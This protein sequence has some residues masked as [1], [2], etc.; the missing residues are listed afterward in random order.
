MSLVL[1]LLLA[2]AIVAVIVW[3]PRWRA[4]RREAWAARPFPPAWRAVLRRRVPLY[5]RLPV[6]LQ[7]QL[8]RHVQVFLAEKQIVGCGGLEVTDEMRVTV[9]AHAGLL[10][11]NRAGPLYP[12][13][14]RVLLYPAAF[15]VERLQP[16]AG[17]VL[18]EERRVLSG[19]SWSRGQVI[20]S[21]PD[22][23]EGARIADDGHNVALHE[24]AHQLDQQSGPA[25]GAPRQPTNALQARWARTMTAEYE[26]LH[27][28]L[29]WHARFGDAGDGGEP[30]PPEL[31]DP[32][33]AT[34]PAEFFAVATEVFFERAP[35]L[36]ER[37]P[38]LFDV[39]RDF[40]RVD[41][42]GWPG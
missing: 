4:S 38:R 35:A 30:E 37:H 13:L 28:R 19:E 5:R 40:Y 10:H 7:Q 9:A 34:A 20:L 36:A 41:P 3:A 42:R 8:R 16:A 21:W 11:L 24:F 22:V 1:I 27:D 33:G 2:V 17:G 15:I 26:A 25:N 18:R 31:I 32:Y 23:L 12:D 39:L 6:P 29:R 14:H